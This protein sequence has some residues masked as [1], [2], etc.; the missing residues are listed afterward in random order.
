MT[1][2]PNHEHEQSHGPGPDF[3]PED[4]QDGLP[5]AS[6]GPEHAEPAETEHDNS[7]PGP[8]PQPATGDDSPPQ[9]SPGPPPSGS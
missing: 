1:S 4:D 8:E 2:T 9:A 6:P 3:T 5:A 7:N